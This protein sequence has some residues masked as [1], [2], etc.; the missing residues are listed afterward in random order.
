MNN[1]IA[2][3]CAFYANMDLDTKTARVKDGI[4][5]TYDSVLAEKK[6]TVTVYTDVANFSTSSKKLYNALLKVLRHNKVKY[7]EKASKEVV[8]KRPHSNGSSPSVSKEEIESID[9]LMKELDGLNIG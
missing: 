3:S 2:L 4:L 6:R 9:D 7:K 5:Y 8:I 1:N